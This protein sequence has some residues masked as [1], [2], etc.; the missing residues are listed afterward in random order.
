VIADVRNRYVPADRPPASTLIGV[1][2]L[3]SPE[4]LIEIEAVAVVD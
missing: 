3:A 2:A 1:T 4:F